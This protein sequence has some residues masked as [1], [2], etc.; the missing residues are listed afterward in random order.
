MEKDEG[1]KMK[2]CSADYESDGAAL[3]RQTTMI[4]KEIDIFHY[5]LTVWLQ[6]VTHQRVREKTSRLGNNKK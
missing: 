1:E 4:Q 6:S 3:L 5:M 2:Q